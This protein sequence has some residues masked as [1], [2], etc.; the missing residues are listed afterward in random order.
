[1][2]VPLPKG[3]CIYLV[4]GYLRDFFLRRRS[5]DIDIAIEGDF[6]KV[7][8]RFREKIEGKIVKY[9][10]FETASIFTGDFRFDFARTRRETYP[11]PAALPVVEPADIGVDL[12]RRDFSI[13]AIGL[14][15]KPPP[16][17]MLDPVNGYQDLRKR[18]IRVLHEKSYQDDPTR[19]F[20]T[21]RYARRLSFAID[22]KTRLFMSRDLHFVS[23]LTAERIINEL[24]LI[25]WERTWLAII[26]DLKN[27]GLTSLIFD[28]PIMK[29]G[30]VVKNRELFLLAHLKAGI[31]ENG[32]ITLSQ[33]K[34]A[35]EV[36]KLERIKAEVGKA[37]TRSRSYQILSKLEPQTVEMLGEVYPQ[38]R[39]KVRNFRRDLN[40]KP[41]ITGN[42][43]IAM[44]LRPSPKFKKI[45]DRIRSLQ[46]DRRIKSATEARLLVKQWISS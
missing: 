8:D 37:S 31:L 27:F 40:L 6:A 4:G 42:D 5:R 9:Q 35:K 32:S 26:R 15:L 23:L 44:G 2:L 20:R 39:L 17:I 14:R 28:R 16:V 34:S 38:L 25:A 29:R 7:F 3:C 41:L 21:Y 1:M 45:L 13:N 43:L 18:K 30:G 33:L 36:K 10:E 19:I 22:R 46:I 11:E 24:R 12:K